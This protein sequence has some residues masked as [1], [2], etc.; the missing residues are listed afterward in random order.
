NFQFDTIALRIHFM[1]WGRYSLDAPRGEQAV[2]LAL[3][4]PRHTLY[5]YNCSVRIFETAEIRASYDF[6]TDVMAPQWDRALALRKV[7]A[8]PDASADDIL[9]DQQIFTG[10]GN[11]IKNEVL[12]RQRLLPSHLVRDLAPRALGRLVTD[13]HAYSQLFYEWR[14]RYELKKH[15]QIYR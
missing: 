12:F 7:K 14:K 2:R 8:L 4:I 10:V 3:A 13:A 9:M 6:R 15:Y 11:I 1:L 5:L